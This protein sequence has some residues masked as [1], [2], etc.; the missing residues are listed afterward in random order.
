MHIRTIKKTEFFLIK[1]N[2]FKGHDPMPAC[3]NEPLLDAFI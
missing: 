2:V 1:K 3:P